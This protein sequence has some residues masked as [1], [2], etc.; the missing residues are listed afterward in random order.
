MAITYLAPQSRHADACALDVAESIFPAASRR[1]CISRWFISNRLR[2]KRLRKRILREQPGLFI[3]GAILA[4]EKKPEEAERA[5][6]A[7]L[8]KMQDA[9]VSAAELDK[10]KIQLVTNE[11]RERETS[12]GKALR[13]RE[14]RCC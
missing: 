3:L 6:L 4:S 9:P 7:E 2:R 14:R 1:A 5:L 11:V 13:W 10:A 8:K 12:N